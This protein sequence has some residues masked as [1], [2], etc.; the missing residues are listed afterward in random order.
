MCS[1]H[2]FWFLNM[3]LWTTGWILCGQRV[4]YWLPLLNTLKNN[5]QV[6][7]NKFVS[8]W[9]NGCIFII[10]MPAFCGS[11]FYIILYLLQFPC[12]RKEKA[13]LPSLYPLNRDMHHLQ[14][15]SFW[16]GI[17]F[18]GGVCLIC[19]GGTKQH[20]GDLRYW[21]PSSFLLLTLTQVFS[22]SL[23]SASFPFYQL[24][25]LRNPNRLFPRQMSA[26][27]FCV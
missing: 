27:V 16:H 11:I 25:S 26:E 13:L 8:C 4:G 21:E 15:A 3:L 14:I 9:I 19:K 10:K 6:N 18:W 17:V 23:L 24:P 5:K 22:A 7:L 1:A 12:P 2:C 20:C